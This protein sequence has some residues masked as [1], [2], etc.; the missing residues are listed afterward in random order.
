MTANG[1]EV[2]EVADVD[3]LIDRGLLADEEHDLDLAERILDEAGK[4][5][6]ENH[7]RVLHLAGRIAWANGDIERASG[8]FQQATDAEPKRPE[9]HID[10]ARCLLLLGDSDDHAEEQVRTA[11]A[12]SNIDALQQGDAKVLL[13]QIRLD[14]DD[15]EEALEVLESIPEELKTHA[16]YLSALADTL[17]ELDRTADALAAVQKAVEAEPDE[18]DYHYQHGL[19]RQS[20]GDIEGGTA[21]MLRVLELEVALRGE[22]PT[23]TDQ[24]VTALRERLEAVMS[25]LPDPLMALVANAPIMVVPHAGEDQVADGA[26]PRASIFFSGRPQLDNEAAELRAIVVARDVLFDEIDDEDDLEEALLVALVSEIADFFDR[27]DLIYEEV[28]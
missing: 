15:A 26:D 11:L 20:E 6:E 12:L 18:P 24:E 16:V 22:T 5:L 2:L 14:D 13:S 8:F 4:R 27:Q 7:P 19:I 28:E 1:N 23:P 10:C 25:E 3:A 21:S 9:I 17:V